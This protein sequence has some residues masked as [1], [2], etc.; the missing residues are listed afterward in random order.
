MIK[1]RVDLWWILTAVVVPVLWAIIL[2]VLW[3]EW[4]LI[5]PY[6]GIY[7]SGI[8]MGWKRRQV[9]WNVSGECPIG[10]PSCYS[11]A[12][13][14]APTVTVMVMQHMKER[15]EAIPGVNYP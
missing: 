11:A 8:L 10:G 12:A 6:L 7:V 3:R 15:H 13:G 4:S 5:I 9:R 14:D 1:G 2:A